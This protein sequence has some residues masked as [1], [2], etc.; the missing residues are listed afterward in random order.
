[1][2]ELS[3]AKKITV[4]L[5]KSLLYS[6]SEAGLDKELKLFFNSTR[7][8]RLGEHFSV[9]SLLEDGKAL[10]SFYSIIFVKI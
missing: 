3:F 1:M 9:K 6:E 7:Q 10:A 8:L 5:I 4:S 2:G